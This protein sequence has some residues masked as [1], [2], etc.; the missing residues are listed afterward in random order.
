M[1]VRSGFVDQN[2]QGYLGETGLRSLTW[3]SITH[4]RNNVQVVHYFNINE[5]FASSNVSHP[6]RYGISLRCLVST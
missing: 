3:S 1:I 6:A 2:G 4:I 5:T